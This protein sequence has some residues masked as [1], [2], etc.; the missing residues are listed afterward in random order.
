[1]EKMMEREKIENSRGHKKSGKSGSVTAFGELMLRLAP[2]GYGRLVQARTF[3]ATYGGAEANVAVSLANF[4]LDAGFVTKQPANELGQAALNALRQFG[5]DT[6]GIARGGSRIGI[7]FLE[8]GASQ[9]PSKVIYDREGSAIARA[10]SADFKWAALLAGR[11]WL[12]LTGITPALGPGPRALCFEAAKAAKDLGLTV[13]LDLNYRR[14]LWTAEEAGAVLGELASLADIG[15]ANEEDPAALFNIRAGD[16]DPAFGKI[17]P[18]S[19]QEAAKELARR[20]GWEQT[21]ITLRTSLSA[22]DNIWAAGLYT[23]GRWL[24]SRSYPVRIVD[25]VG[26][27]DSFAAGL[28]YGNIQGFPPQETLEFAVAASCLKHT[29]QGDFN[30]VSLEEAM[31]LAQGQGAGR[32]QR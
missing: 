6:S 21:A 29:I 30:M 31:K 20:F 7:Y 25:R 18:D 26:A 14:N 19:Y 17:N 16:S 28:I 9:R 22:S 23:R 1:M 27:G 10:D 24:L 15:M 2:E 13:S 32:V 8:K 5:V 4:G 12:H 11:S 3:G